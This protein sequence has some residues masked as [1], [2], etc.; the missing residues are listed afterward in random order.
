MPTV[1]PNMHVIKTREKPEIENGM[2][3]EEQRSQTTDISFTTSL[4]GPPQKGGTNNGKKNR[5]VHSTTFHD[6]ESQKEFY[7]VQI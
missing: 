1:T 6:N 5:L 3:I 7:T 2:L 4:A